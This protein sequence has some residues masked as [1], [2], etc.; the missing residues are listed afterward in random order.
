M[1]GAE[2]FLDKSIILSIPKYSSIMQNLHN[3]VYI[4]ISHAHRSWA[5]NYNI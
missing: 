1:Y 2:C 3:T 5:N 4:P